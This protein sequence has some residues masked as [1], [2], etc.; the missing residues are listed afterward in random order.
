MA[1]CEF[2]EGVTSV[3]VEF[4]AD[5]IAVSF[6]CAR[7]DEELAQSLCWFCNRQ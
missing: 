4:L 2:H 1:E 5:V 7:A 3:N 6:D